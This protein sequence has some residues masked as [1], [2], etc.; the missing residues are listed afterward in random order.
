ML[1]DLAGLMHQVVTVNEN[2]YQS[3]VVAL[4]Q[5]TS[6]LQ[7]SQTGPIEEVTTNGSRGRQSRASKALS[8]ELKVRRPRQHVIWL[9]LACSVKSVGTR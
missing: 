3:I 7:E 9:T 4:R 2:R 8:I 6:R 5:V 1:R